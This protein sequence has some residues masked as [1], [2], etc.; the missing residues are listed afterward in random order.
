MSVQETFRNTSKNSSVIAGI[1]GSLR[2]TLLSVRRK[3]TNTN[4]AIN[5]DLLRDPNWKKQKYPEI[6]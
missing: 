2:G 4:S 5:L 3:K 6:Y 1:I